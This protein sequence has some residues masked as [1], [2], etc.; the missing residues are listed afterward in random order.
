MFLI[1]KS[2]PDIIFYIVFYWTVPGKDYHEEVVFEEEKG[3]VE[4]RVTF[5]VRVTEGKDGGCWC[6]PLSPVVVYKVLE[7]VKDIYM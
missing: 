4:V 6:D 3:Y 7:L 2:V 1:F 5:E